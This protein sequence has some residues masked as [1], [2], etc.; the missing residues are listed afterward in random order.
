MQRDRT[1]GR[2]CRGQVGLRTDAARSAGAAGGESSRLTVTPARRRAS[3]ARR[4]AR[5]RAGAVAQARRAAARPGSTTGDSA[6]ETLQVTRH[7]HAVPAVRRRRARRAR[8][9][10]VMTG[11]VAVE[12]HRQRRDRRAGS[13]RRS[14][15]RGSPALAAQSSAFA[16]FG[17]DRVQLVDAHRRLGREDQRG[18]AGGR[19]RG[20]ARAAERREVRSPSSSSRHPGAPGPASGARPARPAACRSRRRGA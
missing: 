4:A 12:R 18:D 16:G 7:G 1:G 5:D 15:R 20:R 17:H 14:R 19:G 2:Q 8:S 9:T 11:G 13:R 3:R 10:G 6:S